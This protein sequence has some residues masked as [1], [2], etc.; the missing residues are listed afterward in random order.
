[1]ILLDGRGIDPVWVIDAAGGVRKELVKPDP[2]KGERGAGWPAFLPDGRHFLHH[3]MMVKPE[4]NELR[5]RD[6][7]TGETKTIMRTP[8]QVVYAP[9]GY[10]LFVRDRTLVAQR[11]DTRALELHGD[12]I[13]LSEGLGVSDLGLVSISASTTGALATAP[14]WPPRGGSSGSTARA[15]RRRARTAGG[16]YTGLLAVAGRHPSLR[17]ISPRRTTRETSGSA[18]SRAARRHGSRSSPE[19]EF[20]PAWSPDGKKIAYSVQ[21]KGW[22]LYWKDAAGTGEPSC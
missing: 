10:L 20:G 11:F 9:P 13:P 19:Q 21:R 14:G 7:D 1:V 12:P 3:V 2:A 18:T 16:Q 15:R 8:S 17:S 4:D 22:D 5:V 6:L